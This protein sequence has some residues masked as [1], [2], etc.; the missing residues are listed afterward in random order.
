MDPSKALEL[1]KIYLAEHR[2]EMAPDDITVH[3]QAIEALEEIKL[4]T[5]I[6]NMLM[7]ATRA[8]NMLIRGGDI[9]GCK[10]NES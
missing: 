2:Q 6:S 3:E 8:E 7:S 1:M 10:T 4:A 9:I 5:E